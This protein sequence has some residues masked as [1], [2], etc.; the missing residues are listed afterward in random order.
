M[1]SNIN[2][3]EETL[4]KL[5]EQKVEAK[6]DLNKTK[7]ELSEEENKHTE[8]SKSVDD[9]SDVFTGLEKQYKTTISELLDLIDVVTQRLSMTE[10]LKEELN[11]KKEDLKDLQSDTFNSNG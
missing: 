10:K 3:L 5:V 9:K 11:L 8:L 6:H 1:T 7:Q 2:M 4:K